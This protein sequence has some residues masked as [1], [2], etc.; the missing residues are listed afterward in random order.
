MVDGKKSV[1]QENSRKLQ[2]LLREELYNDSLY[3]DDTEFSGEKI[4]ACVTLLG[5]Y[6][7]VDPKEID[8]A[9]KKFMRDFMERHGI[10]EKR[11]KWRNR[12]G[13]MAITCFLTAAIAWTL[14]MVTNRTAC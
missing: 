5:N 3:K 6:E 13:R 9:Q 8:R 1:N 7:S 10:S 14:D 12:I 4:Q 11:R 2:E